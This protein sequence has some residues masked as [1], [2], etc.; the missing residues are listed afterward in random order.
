MNVSGTTRSCDAAIDAAE[1][2]VVDVFAKGRNVAAL[3]RVQF[4]RDHIVAAVLQ[5]RRDLETERRVTALVLVELVPVH[6][7][8]GGGHGTGEIQEDAFALPFR[9]RAEVTPVGGD[10]LEA[11]L[12]E[13]VPGQAHVGVRQGDLLPRRIVEI[14]GRNAGCRLAA[15]QPSAVQF[16]HAALRI[17]LR[18]PRASPAPP[19]RPPPS[20]RG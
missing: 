13:T 1:S 16:V 17:R 18:T 19:G 3:R 20:C 15:E 8:R 14:R 6:G 10:E 5:V 4:H 2:Q 7:D 11:A 12:I 9:Q